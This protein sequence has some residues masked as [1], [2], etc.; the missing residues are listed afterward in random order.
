MI[1]VII[2]NYETE[3][4]ICKITLKPKKDSL[5]EALQQI[6]DIQETDDILKL[7]GPC[8][9]KAS[10]FGLGISSI[11]CNGAYN[12]SNDDKE[13]EEIYKVVDRHFI[14]TGLKVSVSSYKAAL[15]LNLGV[16]V[17]AGL[18]GLGGMTTGYLRKLTNANIY[19]STAE[20][21]KSFLSPTEIYNYLEKN[22][23]KF[24]YLVSKNGLYLSVAY[25]TN[26]YR[27]DIESMDAKKKRRWDINME[28]LQKLID[29]INATET[30]DLSR[31]GMSPEIAK[32]ADWEDN[33]S[34]GEAPYIV[35][36]YD[37]NSE[38]KYRVNK[39]GCFDSIYEDL[40]SEQWIKMSS[41]GNIFPLDDNAEK[42]VR[43][44]KKHDLIPYH[45]IKSEFSFGTCYDVLYVSR[46]PSEWIIERVDVRNNLMS[47]CYNADTDEDEIGA[48]QIS[49]ANG[50]IRRIG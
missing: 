7:G 42:A 25:A 39:I 15:L 48:I 22:K 6:A 5:T 19:Y 30:L 11:K 8:R 3:E 36:D 37:I 29:E 33:G 9:L 44:A 49:V 41:Y 45:V 10:G 23:K 21:A 47:Y 20:D 17:P 28:K 1:T 2:K 46:R 32:L 35:T 50:S 12:S 40:I 31:D 13:P 34:D 14:P 26:E 4:E 43:M 18:F 16:S 38:I 24:Q 27:K